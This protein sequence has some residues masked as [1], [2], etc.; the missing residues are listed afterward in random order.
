[1]KARRLHGF[2]L[3]VSLL[4]LGSADG[5]LGQFVIN[6]QG[7]SPNLT[8]TTGTPSG[9]PTPAINTN[10]R[11]RYRRSLVPTKVTVSTVCAGQSFNLSVLAAQVTMGTPAPEVNLVTGMPAMDFIVGIPPGFLTL[12]T[13]TLQYTAS[14][15]YQQGH[16]ID[17]GNDVHVVTYTLV[18]Q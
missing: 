9:G 12:G 2:V 18:A 11:L 16:S 4:T 14:S 8:I 10:A 13:A 15:T 6:V 7:P 17:F 1:M 5:A 3:A